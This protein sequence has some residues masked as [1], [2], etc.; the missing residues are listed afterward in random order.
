MTCAECLVYY[1]AKT[2]LCCETHSVLTS[3]CFRESLKRPY[4]KPLQ[5]LVA[6]MVI[7]VTLAGSI[8][9]LL[10]LKMSYGSHWTAFSRSPKSEN[11]VN[12]LGPSVQFYEELG[13]RFESLPGKPCMRD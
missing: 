9:N 1:T 2:I 4:S 11:L 10:G 13:P 3:Y 7:M 6:H 8:W 12:E 5:P